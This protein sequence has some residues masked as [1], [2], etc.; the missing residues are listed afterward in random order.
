MGRTL[1][2]IPSPKAL[3][4]TCSPALSCISGA[5]VAYGARRAAD[6]ARCTDSGF[7]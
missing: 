3:W 6:T 5:E 2:T 4:R 7:C 1:S